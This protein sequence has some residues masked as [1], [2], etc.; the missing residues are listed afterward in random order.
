MD[1][2]GIRINL[3]QLGKMLLKSNCIPKIYLMSNKHWLQFD[4]LNSNFLIILMITVVFV[5][6]FLNHHFVCPLKQG[7][8]LY[9]PCILVVNKI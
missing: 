7:C 5:K 3:D 6:L 4:L 8:S 9:L 2:L 1:I